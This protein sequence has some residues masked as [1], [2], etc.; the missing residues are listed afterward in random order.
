MVPLPA[1]KTLLT[2]LESN[3]GS[4]AVYAT[5]EIGSSDEYEQFRVLPNSKPPQLCEQGLSGNSSWSCG[6]S[7]REQAPGACGHEGTITW[8]SSQYSVAEGAKTV[9][10]C[11]KKKWG[12]IGVVQV[13]YMLHHI[14]TAE[15]DIAMSAPYTSSTMLQFDDGVTGSAFSCGTDDRMSEGDETAM[16]ELIRPRGGASLGSQRQLF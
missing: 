12:G 2:T 15:S 16:I 4:A 7:L 13:R 14:T 9:R 5:F 11:D 3:F 8:S 10:G 1:C 6:D